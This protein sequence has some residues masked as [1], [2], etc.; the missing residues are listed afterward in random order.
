M[1]SKNKSIP[2]AVENSGKE[3]VKQPNNGEN[4]SPETDLIKTKYVQA[5]MLIVTKSEERKLSK[6]VSD[7]DINIRPDGLIYYPQVFVRD[8][9][10]SA[11]GRG[12]WALIEHQTIKDEEH[13]KLYFEGSLYVR[14]CFIAKAV[15]EAG[16]YPKDHQGKT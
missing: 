7:L 16:Y 3:L 15:G 4:L 6:K 8:R 13:N 1:E 12:A 2:V 11:F 5:S 9:L 10:N 14:G